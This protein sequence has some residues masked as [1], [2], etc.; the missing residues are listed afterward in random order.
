MICKNYAYGVDAEKMVILHY[1]ALGFE[2]LKHRFK[3]PYGE[4]DLIMKNDESLVFIEVK[5]RTNP[6]HEEFITSRQIKRCCNTALYFLS[7]DGAEWMKLAQ[8]FDL[9]VVINNRIANIIENAWA[10]E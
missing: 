9:V 5:A 4:I 1:Q 2:L 8:R 7:N 10:C 3:T 6:Q